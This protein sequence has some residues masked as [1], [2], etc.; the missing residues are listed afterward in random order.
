MF[1]REMAHRHIVSDVNDLSVAGGPLLLREVWREVA[2]RHILRN[3]I[4]FVTILRAGKTVRVQDLP[5]GLEP[6]SRD[7][8]AGVDT[9]TLDLDQ[10]LSAMIDQIVEHVI[11]EEH[12]NLGRAARRLGISIRTLQRRRA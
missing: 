12:G 9:L 7:S 10:P 2:H 11:L 3:V 4:E 8:A 1:R 6:A 5:P